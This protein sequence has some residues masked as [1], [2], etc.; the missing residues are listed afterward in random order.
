MTSFNKL[1]NFSDTNY[2]YASYICGTLV[3][4]SSLFFIYEMFT[5]ADFGIEIQWNIFKSAWFSPLFVVGFILA[6]VNWGKF[7]HWGG[8]PVNIY[9][10]KYGNK[11]AER[12][13]DI[14]DNMFGHIILPLLGH[15]VIEPIIYACII[16]YPLMCLFA[17]LGFI[18]PYAITLILISISVF[19]FLSPKHANGVAY[20]SV[21]LVLL[22]LLMGGG[23]SWAGWSMES[24]KGNDYSFQTTSPETEEE[25]QTTTSTDNT[26]ED[27]MFSEP[28]QTNSEEQ[29]NNNTST[30][31]SEDDMF[32]TPTNTSAASD[33]DMFKE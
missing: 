28:A 5:A 11:Y 30:S 13:D 21:V 27:D 26:D 3:A 23:L 17:I 33:P 24:S 19:I 20:R 15:F 7:G 2:A 8:Q 6:I 12:N 16:F 9:K 18:L 10:D 31:N 29:Q 1:P 32:D 22:T 4:A 25:I 14:M